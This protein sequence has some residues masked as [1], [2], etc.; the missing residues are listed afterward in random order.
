LLSLVEENG[1]RCTAAPELGKF[2][3]PG[4]RSDPCPIATVLA[5]KALAQVPELEDHPAAHKGAE[6][7][8]SQW[9][10]RRERKFYLF[11]M[12]TDFAKLK[13]PFIWYDILHVADVLSRFSFVHRDTRF[14]Q[15]VATISAKA[16]CNGR[17]TAESMYQAW[18]SWSFADKKQPSPW[19]TFLALRIQKRVQQAV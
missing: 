10:H 17:Y 2:R 18:K 11:A 14:R 15:I 1:W 9:E 12:G 6:M 8:L 3:G 5:L 13:Y 16:D 7:L 19:L 4:K